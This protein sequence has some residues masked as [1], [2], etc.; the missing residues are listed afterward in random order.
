M[1]FFCDLT[2]GG[3]YFEQKGSPNSEYCYIF[4]IKSQG[5]GYNDVQFV[6]K[7]L[8]PYVGTKDDLVI[9]H[10]SIKTEFK[11][12]YTSGDFKIV[13]PNGSIKSFN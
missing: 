2:P 3:C 6:E 4:K 11:T 13:S 10:K 8:N 9:F 7:T 1:D 12:L 5:W